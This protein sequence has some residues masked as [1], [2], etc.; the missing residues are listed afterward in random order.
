MTF[1]RTL[2]AVFVSAVLIAP[3]AYAADGYKFQLKL[4]TENAARDPDGIWE[5][6]YFT[7]SGD[8]ETLPNIYTARLTTPAGEW[9][10]TQLDS[11]CTIQSDC[12]VVLV[13]KRP[14]GEVLELATGSVIMGGSAVLS[15]N[16]KLLHTE[17][18]NDEVQAFTGTYK[19]AP[20]K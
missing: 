20:F 12:A 4:T 1:Y 11:Q 17:E 5:S 3:P 13:L 16:Y 18:I 9:L 7:K 8:P 2:T 10:L 15:Q 6:S 19:V 14:S